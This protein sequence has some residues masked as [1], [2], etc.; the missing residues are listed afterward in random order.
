[1]FKAIKDEKIIAISDTDDKF[2]CMVKDYV[3][4]DTEHVADDY[5]E[6]NGEY[7]L[8]SEIPEPPAP[9]KEEIRQMRIEYRHSHIDDQTLERNRKMANGSWTE[10]DETAYLALDAEVTAWIEE[11]L[12]YPTDP[13]IEEPEEPGE[14][15]SEDEPIE[16]E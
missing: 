4:T 12:P 16:G 7:L 13:I 1:M 3:E 8:K 9:T 14:E 2:L 15:E 6:Y 5:A 11:N 10:E